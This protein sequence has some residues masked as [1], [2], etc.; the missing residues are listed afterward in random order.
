MKSHIPEFSINP[1]KELLTIEKIKELTGQFEMS[2]E[3]AQ[4]TFGKLKRSAQF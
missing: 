2:D 1:K 3:E 4:N